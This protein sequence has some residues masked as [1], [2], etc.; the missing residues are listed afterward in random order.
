M[1]AAA[2]DLV[3]IVVWADQSKYTSK[4]AIV[5]FA[6]DVRPTA[7]VAAAFKKADGH[8]DIRR[9]PCV[10]ERTGTQK[11]TDAAPQSGQY[12]M[13]H[14]TTRRPPKNGK[15]TNDLQSD[16]DVA[17]SA[18]A[19]PLTSDKTALARKDQRPWLRLEAPLATSA[20]HG[21]GICCR[22]TGV[23]LWASIEY[24]RCLRHGQTEEDRG[25]D[26]GRRIQHPVHDQR[27]SRRFE[28]A[29]E[30]SERRERVAQA[31]RRFRH[32]HGYEGQG[33]RGLYGRLPS[34]TIRPRSTRSQSCATDLD[35][36]YNSTTGDALKAA[37]RDIALKISTLYLSQ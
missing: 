33:Y 35:H 2:S 21:P 3:N 23:H 13:V 25:A 14:N 7:D 34:S 27:C 5:P 1:K 26:D 22:R 24:A 8:D 16:C 12:V 15:N 36:F 11:Y 30:L 18:E 32:V 9:T 37:F 29:H 31:R 28:F 20:P 10:V 19:L 6:Y 4:I 17:A